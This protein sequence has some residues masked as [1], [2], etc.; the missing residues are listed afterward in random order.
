MDNQKVS[1]SAFSS[2]YSD[3]AFAFYFGKNKKEFVPKSLVEFIENKFGEGI[4]S[5]WFSIPVWLVNKLQGIN[6]Y[7]VLY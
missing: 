7:T 5:R 2:D 3:R 1:I 6:Y 4:A